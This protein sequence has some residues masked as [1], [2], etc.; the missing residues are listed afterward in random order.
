MRPA[1]ASG[2]APK[3]SLPAASAAARSRV[4]RA[5][6]HGAT[7]PA[8]SRHTASARPARGSRNHIQALAATETV[9][10]TAAGITVRTNASPTAS[11]SAPVRARS[12]PS[13]SRTDSAGAAP[14]RRRYSAARSSVSP[15]SATRWLASRST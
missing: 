7:N 2:A 3:A 13:E 1:A 6:S 12:S 5:V 10:A 8:S 9:A 15:R 11:T 4:A 14:A